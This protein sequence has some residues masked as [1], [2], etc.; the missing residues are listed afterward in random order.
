MAVYTFLAYIA[1]TF[2]MTMVKEFGGITAVLVG[3]TRKAMTICLSFILFPKP[4]SYLYALGGLL[5][6]GSL[7]ANAYMKELSSGS[8]GKKEG[9]VLAF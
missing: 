3:N 9:P 7:T 6:F 2:H 4:I 8:R 1:I 5:V